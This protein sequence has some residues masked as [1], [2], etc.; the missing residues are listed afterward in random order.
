MISFNSWSRE[1]KRYIALHEIFTKN[2]FITTISER[3]LKAFFL[4][5]KLSIFMYV[6]QYYKDDASEQYYRNLFLNDYNEFLK[7]NFDNKK[8]DDDILEELRELQQEGLSPLEAIAEIF[9]TE[10]FDD[11][12]AYRYSPAI[13][14]L[15]ITV[16]GALLTALVLN[17]LTH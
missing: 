17:M 16:S 15:I 13:L 6:N 2:G 12:D 5:P 11:R 3:Q 1:A 14:A 4:R 10:E 9:Y 7:S 8:I